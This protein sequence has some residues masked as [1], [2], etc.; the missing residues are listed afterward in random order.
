MYYDDQGDY[1]QEQ[2]DKIY[3][4]IYEELTSGYYKQEHRVA[5]LLGGQPGSG[6]STF[7]YR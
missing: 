6:K 4:K 2:F 3:D 1:T 7:L 5:Y